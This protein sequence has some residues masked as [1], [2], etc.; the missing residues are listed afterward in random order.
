[1]NTERQAE[2]AKIV[3]EIQGELDGD[4]ERREAYCIVVDGEGW[5]K[6]VIGIVASRVVDRYN[7][8][9]LVI[10]REGEQAQGSGRS[11]E[12]F[13]LMD[14]LE[15]CAP[16]FSRFGGHAHAAG[17]ALPSE[18]I[19]ELRAALEAWAREKLTPEDLQRVLKYDAAI[20]LDEVTPQLFEFLEKLEPFGMGNPGP[21]FTASGVRVLAPPRVLKEKHI[22][23]RVRQDGSSL[24][25]FPSDGR[26]LLTQ[27]GGIKTFDLLGWRMAD[28]LQKDA[29]IAGESLDIAFT[30]E[31][32]QHPD[33]GGLQLSLCDFARSGTAA[34]AASATKR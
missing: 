27:N 6:G 9:A 14:A 2:E 31:E 15:S 8:P 32:N 18:R 21:V 29:V 17:F 4:P 16:M 13:H 10:S 19:P 28:R 25:A 12:A 34:K 30:I 5:H 1:L 20:S 7:R 33:F 11:I 3:A 22:K 24:S 23:L 26:A